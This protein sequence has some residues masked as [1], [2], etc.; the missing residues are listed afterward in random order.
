MLVRLHRTFK[1]GL[2]YTPLGIANG[3]GLTSGRNL[4]LHWAN[5]ETILAWGVE[6]THHAVTILQNHPLTKLRPMH[7]FQTMVVMLYFVSFWQLSVETF[8]EP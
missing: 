5:L 6:L 4:N 7:L 1:E 8:R 2:K 3:R